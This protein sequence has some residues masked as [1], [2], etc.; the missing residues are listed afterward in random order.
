MGDGYYDIESLIKSRIGISPNN[1][2]DETKEASDFVTTNSGG[3]GAVY[4]ACKYLI[5]LINENK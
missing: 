4:E 2:L 3:E 1:A 5:N